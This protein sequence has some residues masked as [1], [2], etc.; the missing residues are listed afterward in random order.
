MTT[1]VRTRRPRRPGRRW[2]AVAAAA[3][4]A[5]LVGSAVVSDGYD[6]QQLVLDDASVWVVNR[7]GGRIGQA[8]AAIAQLARVF[9]S[10]GVR[11][12]V[13]QG[14]G[15]LAVHDPDANTL[16]AVDAVRAEI[17]ETVPLPE[18]VDLVLSAGDEIAVVNRP[19]GEVWF[20]VFDDVATFSASSEPSLELGGD[21]AMALDENGRFAAFS[22]RTGVLTSGTTDRS[23]RR[24]S[25]LP[26]AA[27]VSDEDEPR[28]QTTLVAGRPVVLRPAAGELWSD[29][30]QTSLTAIVGDLS[31]LRLAA[32]RLDGEQ[33]LLA[34]RDGA[35]DVP[36]GGGTVRARSGT[37]VGE[38][39]VP[40]HVAG[41]DFLVWSDG[42]ALRACGQ[43]PSRSLDLPGATG[44]LSL[45]LAVNGQTVVATD[46]SRG[47]SWAVQR[48]GELIDDWNAFAD[49][50]RVIEIE[51]EDRDVPPDV[52]PEQAPPVAVDDVLGARPG[53]ANILP[54]LVNDTDANGDPLLIVDVGELPPE[55][56]RVEIVEN[57]QRLQ[58]TTT[59]TAAGEISFE[60]RISDGHGGVA[61]ATVFLTLRGADEN[62][63]PQQVRPTR[64]SMAS[65]GSVAVHTLGDWVDPEA[66]PFYLLEADGGAFSQVSSSPDGRIDVTDDASG[67]SLEMI[68]VT[69]SDGRAAAPGTVSVSVGTP[70]SVPIIAES[71]TVTGYVAQELVLAPLGGVRGGTGEVT[72]SGMAALDPVDPLRLS[73]DYAKGAATISSDLPGTH[74][75]SYS[76]T[77]GTQTATGTIRIEIA[78]PISESGPP[79]TVPLTAFLSPRQTKLV[80]VLAA[81]SDP[82]GRVL[83]VASVQ[84]QPDGSGLLVETLEQD[85]LRVSLLDRLED[86]SHNVEYTITNGDAAATGLVTII[87][88]PD[89]SR[90]QAPVARDDEVVVRVGQS[91]D[92]RV[93]ANDEQPD[94]RPIS[95]DPEL[96]SD[97]A[98]GEGTAFVSGDL[99][100]YLAPEAAGTY[101]VEYRVSSTD[102]Q[103]AAGEVVFVVR[104]HDEADNRAPV[105]E[106]VTARVRSG[107]EVTIPIPLD[108]LDLD[109]DA[110]TLI[111]PIGSAA[112][113]SVTAT[114]PSSI[115][116]TAGQ[117][118]VGTDTI[119]Y[120][121]EDSLGAIGTAVL[122]IGVAPAVETFAPPTANDD[123]VVTRP[124]STVRVAVL[125]NDSDP[126]HAPLTV[127]G[128]E[129]SEPALMPGF[130][131]TAVT[132]RAP[133][134]EG[135]YGVLYTITSARGLTSSAW[136]SI[137]VDEDAPLA[138]PEAR[139][140]ELSLQDVDDR[141]TA[142]VAVLD[143]VRLESGRHVS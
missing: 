92:V 83:S 43:E 48:D 72:L 42:T 138:R 73:A 68:A 2:G 9:D 128:V 101:R 64:T 55:T 57:G 139:D 79:V 63:P 141:R 95:L 58:V 107:G 20:T 74:L 17:V 30:E 98:E 110:V 52:E 82:T 140:V 33:V 15:R 49:P 3:L 51:Q 91:V 45:S 127:S 142:E 97:L 88:V 118:A 41:C 24:T 7:D 53:R 18:G 93:L 84:A 5:L 96:V 126:D 12:Q 56:G 14:N 61:A 6:E 23:E 47:A 44:G 50:D 19:S 143:A 122:R 34:H 120:A 80:D 66:D 31:S 35:V 106:P 132:L 25:T 85:L 65:G 32:P 124:G 46:P 114:G 86:G 131:D 16:S 11:P 13:L 54:V 60:Y 134:V 94:G 100:R 125:E 76:V 111:G 102:G 135:A 117:Y 22:Q 121:V 123:L 81:A 67:E 59:P 71:F 119:E 29:G 38:P 37:G 77:D 104:E 133:E 10:G 78:A 87:E 1:G 129:T 89:P 113:G 136:I 99:V 130:T 90:L 137:Q 69:V 28:A 70:G 75:V 115:S 40:V 108:G 62:G 112:L 116:Y 109:G 39:A 103:W 105:P 27:P 36:L 26:D 8:N 4:G 21:L